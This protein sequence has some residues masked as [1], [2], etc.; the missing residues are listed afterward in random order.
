MSR[1][2]RSA[3]KPYVPKALLR[4]KL[5]SSYGIEGYRRN[6]AAARAFVLHGEEQDNFTYDIANRDQLAAMLATQLGDD[7]AD[8]RAMISELDED[9]AFDAALR[10]RLAT[11]ADRP[12]SMPFGRRLGWYATVR[13]TKPSLV[14]E[15]GVHDGLG[16]AVLLRALLRNRTEGAPGELLSFDIR[17]DVGWLIPDDLREGFQLVVGDSTQ[18]LR[19]R[20]RGKTVDLFIHDSYHTYDHERSELDAVIDHLA[21]DGVI[22]SDNAH[23]TDALA[24]FAREHEFDFAFFMER[25]LDTWFGGA[26]LGIAR[27]R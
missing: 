27:P 17:S 4:L 9:H 11:R 25:P 18:E 23:A 15:T 6:P 14:V 20:L 3:L 10:D 21:G 22:I 8:V 12:S 26:G 24:D 5:L 19:S 13:R 1:S 2:V 7:P 16:S